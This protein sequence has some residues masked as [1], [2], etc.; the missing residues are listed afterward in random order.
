MLRLFFCQIIILFPLITFLKLPLCSDCAVKFEDLKTATNQEEIKLYDTNKEPL[1]VCKE[2]LTRLKMRLNQGNP[3]FSE[4]RL[5]PELCNMVVTASF[6]QGT[7]NVSF[8]GFFSFFL[9]FLFS[10]S[11]FLLSFS[12]S[13]TSDTKPKVPKDSV[14]AVHKV[15]MWSCFCAIY[16]FIN[17][18]GQNRGRVYLSIFSVRI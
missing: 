9:F 7:H 2:Q 1:C 3:Q 14:N 17:I 12:L 10:F 8:T 18:K 4:L 6:P 11:L 15:K 16:L 5:R 13:V